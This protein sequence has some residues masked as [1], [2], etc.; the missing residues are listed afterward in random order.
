[1]HALLLA[2]VFFQTIPIVNEIRVGDA[3]TARIE[4]QTLFDVEI[5]TEP[6]TVTVIPTRS[7]VIVM[8]H[9]GDGYAG[10]A[11]HSFRRGDTVSLY[12]A[13]GYEHRYTLTRS[14]TRVGAPMLALSRRDAIVFM[15][16]T[17]LAGTGTLYWAGKR[18]P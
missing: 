15:T 2:L 5:T 8:A 3:F 9:Y 7:T 12:D 1:M 17:D 6:D 16:C 13:S 18:V 4:Y 11:F 10:K 14:W